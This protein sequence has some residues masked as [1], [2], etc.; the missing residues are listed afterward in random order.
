MAIQTHE[1]LLQFHPHLHALVSDGCFGEDGTFYLLPN[2]SVV[3]L[4][5]VFSHHVFQMLLEEG[6][7]REELVKKISSWKHSGFSVHKEVRVLGSDRKGLENL[8]QY[9]LRAPFS[10]ILLYLK[11]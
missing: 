9:I 1:N 7:I 8:A 11:S 3:A 6:K 2:N 10:P 4:E 5:K